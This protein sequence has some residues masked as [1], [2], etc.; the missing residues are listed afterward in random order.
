LRSETT[1]SIL[2]AFEFNVEQ[3][4]ILEFGYLYIRVYKAG[5][6]GSRRRSRK[7]K[8]IRNESVN[9]QGDGFQINRG[10]SNTG[11]YNNTFYANGNHAI[12]LDSGRWC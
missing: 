6:R 2:I 11:V 12:S 5:A 8:T 10:A 3:V 9:N 4:Y 1:R 7:P